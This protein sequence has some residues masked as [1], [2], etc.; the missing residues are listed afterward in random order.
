VLPLVLT[1]GAQL[2]E[3]GVRPRAG[4]RLLIT[5]AL[6]S[7]GRAAVYVARQHGAYVIAGVRGKQ[8]TAAQALGADEVLAV[9]DKAAVEN[10]GQVDAIADNV[11]GEVIGQLLPHL[12]T[13]G[14]LATVV[15]KPKVAEGYDLR[16]EAVWAQPD[17]ARLAALA[18]DVARG[19]FAIPI[20]KRL[21]LSD[22]RHGQELAEK[23]AGG[24]ILLTP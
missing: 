11:G 6:G 16:V 10:L 21:K 7:V 5:G 22:I 4:E 2:I 13:G 23:G 20:S 18:Q 9:D 1:T 15:G 24:K 17:A 12:K 14:V 8:V 3:L 19:A